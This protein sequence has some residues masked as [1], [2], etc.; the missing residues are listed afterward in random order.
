MITHN[1]ANVRT[2]RR[3]FAYLKE[4]RQCSE[5]S[6]DRVAKALNRFESYTRFRDFRTFRTEQAVAF[7]RHLSDQ[8]S[9]KTGH[10]LSKSTLHSTLNAL[11]NFFIWVAGQ[12]GFRSRLN[13]SDADYFH[14]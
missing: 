8:V 13:Y 5:A 3:Y 11:R 14:L 7:K 12:P 1:P 9:S 2:K 10:K 4:A 6:L